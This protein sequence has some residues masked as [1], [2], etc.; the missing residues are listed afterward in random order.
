[1]LVGLTA[2]MLA[3]LGLLRRFAS[4]KDKFGRH[5]E[6]SEAIQASP[7]DVLGLAV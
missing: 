4:R 7:F 6:R 3:G 5:C 2:F 1:M